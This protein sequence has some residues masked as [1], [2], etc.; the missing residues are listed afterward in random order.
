MA[1]L[2]KKKVAGRPKHYHYEEDISKFK[3]SI[4]DS[5]L[6][7]KIYTAMVMSYIRSVSG[8]ITKVAQ[9]AK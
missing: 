8:K 1:A 3:D 2:N 6:K 5:L 7:K 9:P 4:A